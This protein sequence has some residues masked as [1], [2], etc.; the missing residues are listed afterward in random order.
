M[1]DREDKET[2]KGVPV[3]RQKWKL[4]SPALKLIS[5]SRPPT[6]GKVPSEN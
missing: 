6:N 2:E 4:S 1:R 5:T 3:L